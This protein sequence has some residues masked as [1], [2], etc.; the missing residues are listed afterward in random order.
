MMP[1]F[2]TTLTL[3]HPQQNVVLYAYSQRFCRLA[4]LY[5][6]L[7]CYILLPHAFLV[8]SQTAL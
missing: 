7:V 6:A 8:I 2:N 3:I 5:I 1:S 4:A